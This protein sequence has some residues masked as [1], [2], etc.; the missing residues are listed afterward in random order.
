VLL[1]YI[2]IQMLRKS[3]KILFINHQKTV[4]ILVRPKDITIYLIYDRD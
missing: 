4:G 3:E 2:A 1:R